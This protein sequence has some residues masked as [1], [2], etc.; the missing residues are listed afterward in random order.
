TRVKKTTEY[1]YDLSVK[2][3]NNFVSA[4]GGIVCHNTDGIWLWVPKLFP[5]EFPV[6]IENFHKKNGSKV[7]KVSLIDKI[8][9]E[10]VAAFSRNDNYWMNNGEIEKIKRSS[11]S[12]IQFEQD[13]PYDF[14]FMMGKKKYIVYNY[15]RE[16]QTWMEEELT[17][18]ESKRADFSK[19]Q[20]YFQETIISTYLE[21][22]NP[23]NPITL[24][25]LYENANRQA[26]LIRSEMTDGRMEPSYFVK[27]KAINK[28][29]RAYKS[30]LPQVSAAYIL[31]DLGYSVDPGT[32]IQML[33]IKGNHVI[34]HQLFDF[35]FKKIK[36][37]LVKHAI[38]TL[39]FMLGELSTKEDQ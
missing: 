35:E 4:N 10:K 21:Y 33:N 36:E 12:L 9:N 14:Q 13:G 15:N 3:N 25:Q 30:K 8:L 5:L 34:P 17:G 28:P 26:N 11:K 16:N 22:F 20:K 31:K 23:E 24:S 38:A 32:R 39:S 19:L 6:T 1:V 37:V 29:L 27:P 18:L 2:D 7:Y